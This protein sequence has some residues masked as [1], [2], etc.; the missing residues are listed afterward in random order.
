MMDGGT[1][2]EI[3]IERVQ[4]QQIQSV[5]MRN[6]HKM[7]IR[8]LQYLKII[9]L[10][11]FLAVAVVGHPQSEW[12]K[13]ITAADGTVIDIYQPQPESFAG[14]TLKSR[15]AFSV[16]EPGASDPIF[17]VF[18]STATVETD[19]DARL[20]AIESIKVNDL[21]IPADTS[22]SEKSH[23]ESTLEFF[24]PRVAGEMPLDEVLSSLDEALENTNLSKDIS[25]QLPQLIYRTQRTMLVLIDG[26]PKLKMSKQ[27]GLAVVVN[28]PFTIVQNKDGR[29]YLFG[30][31]HWYV[32]PSPTGP[33]RYTYDKVKHKFKKIARELKKTASK[34]DDLPTDETVDNPVYSIVVSTVPAE[35]IQSDGNPDLTPLAGTSLLYVKNSDNDIFVDTR[36][37]QY[38]VLLSGRWYSAGALNE[39]STWQYVAPDQLPA[40]FAKIPEGSPKDAVLASVPGTPAA[41]EAVMD[42]QVPQTAKIDRNSAVTHVEYDGAPQF[43]PIA[44]THMEYA[45]NSNYTVLLY[46]GKFYAVDNGVWFIADN[47]MGPWS[48]SDT[49]PGE[50]DE[51]PPT[52]P[53][54]NAKFV[55]VYQSTPDYVY[56]G[57]TPGYLNS[58]VD[59]PTVVYGTGYDYDPW[60]GDYYYPRPWTWGFDMCY[61]PW[62]GWGFGAGYDYD[63]FDDGFGWDYGFGYGMG[64]GGWYGGG[65]WGGASAYRPAYRNWH[66]GRFR[67][68]RRGGYYGRDAVID[69]STH[70]HMRY[71]NNIYRGRLGVIS[72][73]GSGARNFASNDRI[74]ALG[75]NNIFTDRQGNIYRRTAQGLWQQRVNR[76][77]SPMVNRGTGA[78]RYLEQQRQMNFRGQVRAQNFQR[79]SNFGG[80]RFSGGAQFGGGGHLGGGG[81]FAGGKR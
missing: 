44:G 34:N 41:K 67:S 73:T 52:C 26:K 11:C 81:H 28:T 13:S 50:M 58:Y 32:A 33:Y 46:K 47:A 14:N 66:G 7:H 43:K 59:G 64:W 42:A 27:W 63:W 38:Y 35:L 49:R 69:R 29:F 79:A 2:N 53:V 61:N 68:D 70:M 5:K 71:G 60:M 6:K 62:S 72:R 22:R 24:I 77:W 57:Y 75:G 80:M 9:F 55:Y 1:S 20:V 76:S 17:G 74:N 36:T 4:I 18:W 3:C 40:D 37:Q 51:I 12:P 19:R 30:G 31:G 39:N 48:V 15:S 8:P 21:K 56:D 25:N 78:G 23:I 65:W 54:Y 45:V 10:V 16:L